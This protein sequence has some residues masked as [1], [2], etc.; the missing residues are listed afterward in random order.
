LFLIMLHTF[1][2][3]ML[4]CFIVLSN[5]FF[6][7]IAIKFYTINKKEQIRKDFKLKLNRFVNIA[8]Y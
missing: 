4:Y 3:I 1:L 5:Y 8:I 2:S 7:K 6:Q